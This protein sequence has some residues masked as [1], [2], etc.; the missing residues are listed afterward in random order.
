MCAAVHKCSRKHRLGG[1][2]TLRLTVSQAED[3]GEDEEEEFGVW[4][5][6]YL[7]FTVSC[8]TRSLATLFN[9]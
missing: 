3:F 9:I 6:L 5:H 1:G 2:V 7:L 8:I 4:E